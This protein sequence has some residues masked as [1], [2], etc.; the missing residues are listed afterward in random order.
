MADA[1]NETSRVLLA[2]PET[3]AYAVED[4]LKDD[5]DEPRT[6][7]VVMGCS[8]F[9]DNSEPRWLVAVFLD[10]EKAV[11]CRTRLNEW[12]RDVGLWH[13]G[14]PDDYADWDGDSFPPDDPD[15][16]CGI[17]GTEYTV[18]PVPLRFN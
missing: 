3:P 8:F 4:S 16:T 17:Y 1:F 9:E 7:Y 10:Q 2:N 11:A 5:S 15:F 13:V 12:C 6:M 14:G 18:E